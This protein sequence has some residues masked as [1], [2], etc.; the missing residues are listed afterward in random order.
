MSSK[1]EMEKVIFQPNKQGHQ[2]SSPNFKRFTKNVTV[3]GEGEREREMLLPVITKLKQI[4][5]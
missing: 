2:Q 5:L 1:L 3:N 4:S